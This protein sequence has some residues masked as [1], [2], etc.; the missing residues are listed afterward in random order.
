[1]T[2]EKDWPGLVHSKEANMEDFY[3]IFL[4]LVGIQSAICM[5]YIIATAKTDGDK[6]NY[7]AFATLGFNFIML[8]FTALLAISQN[9]GYYKII[10]IGG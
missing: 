5:T 9:L 1:M 8:L 10:A 4:F 7:I 3:R 6:P 2:V